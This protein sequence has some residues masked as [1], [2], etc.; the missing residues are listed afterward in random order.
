MSVIVVGGTKYAVELDWQALTSED[1]GHL[2]E[3]HRI[4]KEAG[5]KYFAMCNQDDPTAPD[6]VGLFPDG[7]PR[8]AKSLAAAIIASGKYP[9]NCAFIMPVSDTGEVWFL[10]VVGGLPDP[11]SDKIVGSIDECMESIASAFMFDDAVP[12]YTPISTE[13]RE[14]YI[15][16]HQSLD[17]LVQ[18][19]AAAPKPIKTKGNAAMAAM[20]AG[21]IVIVGMILAIMLWPSSP[22]KQ[23]SPSQLQAQQQAIAK[24]RA[25][26]S[27]A[28]LFESVSGGAER[29]WVL[30]VKEML[31]DLPINLDGL[32][33]K[34]IKC[35]NSPVCVITYA[36]AGRMSIP[37]FKSRFMDVADDVA[38]SIDGKA[39]I[40]TFNFSDR[41]IPLLVDDI[42][43]EPMGVQ[44]A[45]GL[46]NQAPGVRAFG[47]ELLI[48]LLTLEQAYP[49]GWSRAVQAPRTAPN[50]PAPGSPGSPLEHTVMIG[51]IDI[52]IQDLWMLKAVLE[53]LDSPYIFIDKFEVSGVD[54]RPTLRMS[55]KYIV[56]DKAGEL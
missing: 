10:S 30:S 28:K 26:E 1:E 50:M 8:G 47:E 6:A 33:M 41:Q 21:A 43:A 22:Q 24:K 56:Q 51:G 55:A 18:N 44:D 29:T 13:M 36:N 42:R 52:T 12:V 35:D 40:L 32:R 16:E 14:G 37:A 9:A 3:A 7:A 34:E 20:V 49:K 25:Q 5:K 38:F 45:I 15:R 27:V 4:A 48:R 23:L 46:V 19:H 53:L 2:H 54:T 39:A 11:N 17:G 31:W